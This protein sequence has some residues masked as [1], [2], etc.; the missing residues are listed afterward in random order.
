MRMRESDQDIFISHA[1]CSF[2]QLANVADFSGVENAMVERDD[3]LRFATYSADWF[4]PE[5]GGFQ[6][7]MHTRG[8]VM[9]CSTPHA[10]INSD[11]RCD[12]AKSDRGLATRVRRS[13]SVQLHLLIKCPEGSEKPSKWHQLP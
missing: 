3:D 1:C 2:Y 5:Q 8:L 6:R 12:I 4:K 11:R 10:V 9:Q 13:E 7:S